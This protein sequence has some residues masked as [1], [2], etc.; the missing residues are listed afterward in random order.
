MSQ[1]T[2]RMSAGMYSNLAE[3]QAVPGG[4]KVSSPGSETSFIQ[5][6]ST[7]RTVGAVFHGCPLARHFLLRLTLT[8]QLQREPEEGR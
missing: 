8:H 4:H 6:R 2:T 5:G 3:V 1:R 7:N